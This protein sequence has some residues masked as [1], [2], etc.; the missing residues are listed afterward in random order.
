[1]PSAHSLIIFYRISPYYYCGL[2][3]LQVLHT[4]TRLLNSDLNQDVFNRNLIESASCPCGYYTEDATHY[5]LH[6]DNYTEQR[7]HMTTKLNFINDVKTRDLIYGR[8]DLSDDE[9]ESIFISVHLYIA[10][11][12]RLK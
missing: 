10:N 1:M 6:C 2:R 3:K 5:F 9:N 4:R 11:T 8:E 7:Q 12:K